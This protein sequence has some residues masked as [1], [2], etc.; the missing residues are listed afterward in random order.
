MSCFA[1]PWHSMTSD[2]RYSAVKL[3]HDTLQGIGR[4]SRHDVDMLIDGYLESLSALL[5][6]KP[7]LLG[8]DPCEADAS[9]FA[10]LDQ[11]VDGRMVSKEMQHMVRDYPNLCQFTKRI[12]ENFYPEI[13]E[14]MPKTPSSARKQ[15]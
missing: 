4:H 12:K 8:P 5:G 10:V 6:D 1:A 14:A 13:C 15:A 11:F 3:R 9:L 2:K 7:Y